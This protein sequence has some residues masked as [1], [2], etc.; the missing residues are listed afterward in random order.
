MT[1]ELLPAPPRLRRALWASTSFVLA[2]TRCGRST[3]TP[4]AP[5][6]LTGTCPGTPGTPSAAQAGAVQNI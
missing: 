2:L 1:L 3:L 6:A 4:T 5:P